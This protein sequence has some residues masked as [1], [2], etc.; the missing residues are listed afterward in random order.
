MKLN[1]FIAAILFLTLAVFACSARIKGPFVY[2]RIYTG[3][4]E[5]IATDSIRIKIPR[6]HE[7]IVLIN[8]AYTKHAQKGRQIAVDAIDS[9][10]VWMPT[11]PD[12]R[13]T[14]VYF[15]PYGWCWLLE[16]TP[17]ITVFVFCKNGYRMWGNGGIQ[18]CGKYILLVVKDGSVTEF[19]KTWKMSDDSFR[20]KV[21]DLVADDPVLGAE[22]I[23]SR[24]RRDKTLRMLRLYNPVY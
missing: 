21:A 4:E 10:V 23:K 8:D 13:H 14:I 17:R 19:K 15:K 7:N 20:R 1:S 2:S 3:S 12:V 22:I 24:T 6:K 5:I 9:L 18:A 11:S 16:K